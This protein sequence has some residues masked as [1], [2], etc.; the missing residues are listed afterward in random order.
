MMYMQ[1]PNLTPHFHNFIPPILWM[2]DD[3]SD[4]HRVL[5][6]SVINHILLHMVRNYSVNAL[7]HFMHAVQDH[8]EL[9]WQGRAQLLYQVCN[10]IICLLSF[11]PLF[12]Q[13]SLCCISIAA[14]W[15][16]LFIHAC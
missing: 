2:L 9:R 11:I 14:M 8:T 10:I 16:V 6:L 12:R 4:Y 1:H 5:A 15:Y 3:Y 13:S 7:L